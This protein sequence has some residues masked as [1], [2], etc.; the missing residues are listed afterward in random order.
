MQNPCIYFIFYKIIAKIIVNLIGCTNIYC[1]LKAIIECYNSIKNR[2]VTKLLLRVIII[3]CY[4]IQI[5]CQTEF[6]ISF[7]LIQFNLNC[8]YLIKLSFFHRLKFIIY[9]SFQKINIQ[10]YALFV[11]IKQLVL[12]TIRK[13]M[14]ISEHWNV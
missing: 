5:V 3:Y 9:F 6:E 7:E 11:I 8:L 12:T 13:N 14:D 1:T 2:I 10:N 4:L